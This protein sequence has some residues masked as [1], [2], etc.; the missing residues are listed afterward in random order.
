MKRAKTADILKDI[1][2]ISGILRQYGFDDAKIE[3]L[4][5][6]RTSISSNL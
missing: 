4:V 1:R 2:E 5:H 3:K 6:K